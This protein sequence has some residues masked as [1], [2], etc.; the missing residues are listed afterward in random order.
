MAS[1]DEEPLRGLRGV[2]V[3]R[4]SISE[5]VANTVR[6][7]IIRGELRPGEA[8]PEA[9][10]AASL[11]VS[12]NTVREAFRLLDA[13]GLV[14]RQVHRS[15]VVK[16]LTEEDVADIYTARRALELRAIATRPTPTQEQ[17]DALRACVDDA[18]AAA[19]EGDWARV[20]TRNLH[21][22]QW[23]VRLL[24]SRRLDEFFSRILAE[25][26]LGFATVVDQESYFGPYVPENRQLFELIVAGSWKECGDR[27]SRYL[28]R[29]EPAT[30]EA[31]R[32]VETASGG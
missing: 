31:V 23:I 2:Q 4:T 24:G 9:A 10:L 15:V 6:D 11:G 14:A 18:E 27:L 32:A 26:R 13:G 8:L 21:F 7:L 25:L 30:R 28:D 16:R 5:Q 1:A 29:S 17:L 22:H 3:D 12:R 20:A 19:A